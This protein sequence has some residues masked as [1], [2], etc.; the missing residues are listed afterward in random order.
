MPSFEGANCT[1][2]VGGLGRT[3]ACMLLAVENASRCANRP[4]SPGAGAS[5]CTR[6]AP[7]SVCVLMRCHADLIFYSFKV[8]QCPIYLT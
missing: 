4:S 3:K 1:G 2:K 8:A 5:G 7:G 6:L